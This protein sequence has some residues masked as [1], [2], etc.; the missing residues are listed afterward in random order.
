MPIDPRTFIAAVVSISSKPTPSDGPAPG[1]RGLW[2]GRALAAF[3]VLLWGGLVGLPAAAQM[4]VP[5][6]F[7][8]GPTGAAIYS[9]PIRVPPGTAG[10]APS[11]S[12]S[13][14]SQGGNGIVGMGW[15]LG[16]LPSIGRCPQTIAQDGVVG[17]VTFTTGDPLCVNGQRLVVVSGSYGADGAEYRAELDGFS[18]IISHGATGYGPAWFQVWTKAGQIMEF[19]HTADSLV[20]AQGI[21]APSS[22]ALDQISDTAGNYLTVTYAQNSATGETHPQQIN[23]TGNGRPNASLTPY[24]SVKFVYSTSRPDNL[25]YYVKGSA[26]SLSVLLTDIQTF[27]TTASGP[28]SLVADYHLTYGTGSGSGRS[29][30]SSIAQCT[31]AA[32]TNC[33]PSTT[34]GYQDGGN[35]ASVQAGPLSTQDSSVVGY[36][37]FPGNFTGSGRTD[38]LWDQEDIHGLSTGHRV[39]WIA[40]ANGTFKATPVVTG[41]GTLVGARPYLGSFTGNGRTDILWDLEQPSFLTLGTQQLWLSNGDGTFQIKNNIA[42]GSTGWFSDGK[43]DGTRP[44]VVDL[45]GDGRSDVLWLPIN[46]GGVPAYATVP[47]LVWMG[48]GDGT[49]VPKQLSYQSSSAVFNT[50]VGAATPYFADFDGDGKIDILWTN[51]PNSVIWFGNGDGTFREVAIV[52]PPGDSVGTGWQP[53]IGNFGDDGDAGILWDNVDSNGLST[54]TRK[55]WL[56]HGDGSFSL[57]SNFSNL[58]NN[59]SQSRIY[60]ADFQGTGR[61]DLFFDY[62]NAN[63]TSKGSGGQHIYRSSGNATFFYTEGADTLAGISNTNGYAPIIADFTGDGKADILWYASDVYGGA[64]GQFVGWTSDGLPSDVIQSITTGLGGVTQISHAAIDSYAGYVKGSSASYP[65]MDYTGALWV[66]SSWTQ[67]DGIGGA[68][69]TSIN[70]AGAQIDNS[71]RGFM[72]FGATVEVD[73]VTGVQSWKYYN[74]QFPLTGMLAESKQVASGVLLNDTIYSYNPPG[75]PVN[76]PPKKAAGRWLV[77]LSQLQTTTANDLETIGTSAKTWA[78]PTST[79]TFLRDF[80]NYNGSTGN[81]YGDLLQVKSVT[82]DGFTKEVDNTSLDIVD[83]NDWILGLTTQ[84]VTTSTAGPFGSTTTHHASFV[85]DTTAGAPTIGRLMQSFVEQGNTPYQ[86][87]SDYGYDVFGNRNL[88][89]VKGGDLASRTATTT[90]YD[91]KGQFPTTVSQPLSAAAT[92]VTQYQYDPRFGT[93]TSTM[94]NGVSTSADYDGFGRKS[95]AVAADG[96][97]VAYAYATVPYHAYGFSYTL[98]STPEA[99]TGT[100]IGPQTLAYYD[101]LGRNTVVDTQSFDGAT[102]SAASNNAALSRVQI[103]YDTNGNLVK[104]SR[105]FWATSPFSGQYAVTTYDV[106]NRPLSVTDADGTVTTHDYQGLASIDRNAN[107]QTLTTHRNSQGEVTTVTDALNNT[108]QYT[109]DGDGQPTTVMDPAGNAVMMKY[110]I[111]GRMV[112]KIDPDTGIWSYGYDTLSEPTSIVDAK[113]QTVTMGYDWAGRMVQRTERDLTSTWSYDAAQYGSSPYYGVGRLASVSTS[114]GFAENIAYDS[115][116]RPTVSTQTIGGA[117][118]SFTTGYDAYS[119]IVS[120]AYPSG[121]SLN[122]SFTALGYPLQESETGPAVATLS[123]INQVDVEFRVTQVAYGNGVQTTRGFN[124]QNGELQSIVAGANNAVQSLSYGYDRV[125]NIL[126]RTDGTQGLSET[127]GYDALNRLVSAQIGANAAVT[128]GY[129]QIGNLTSKSDIGTLTYGLFGGTGPHQLQSVTVS[130]SSPYAASYDAGTERSYTWTSFDMPATVSAGGQTI[131]F[132]YD[133]GHNRII[134]T[135]PQ[136]TTNYLNDPI[137]GASVERIASGGTAVWNN[138]FS[139]GEVV[140][141]QSSGTTTAKTLYFHRDGLGSV[142]AVSDGGGNVAQYRYDAWGARRYPTGAIDGSGQITSATDK[143]FTGQEELADVGLVHMNARLYDPLTARFV[144]ADP[145]GLQGGPNPY[146]YVYNNPLFYTDPTGLDGQQDPE[147]IT[148]YGNRPDPNQIGPA[149]FGGAAGASLS[150]YFS[151]AYRNPVAKGPGLSGTGI[152]TADQTNPTAGVDHGDTDDGCTYVPCTYFTDGKN[153]DGVIAGQRPDTIGTPNQFDGLLSSRT[154]NRG[155]R[156]ANSG[157]SQYWQ[158]WTQSTTTDANGNP[159]ETDVVTGYKTPSY[160]L[161]QEVLPFGDTMMFGRLPPVFSPLEQL[162]EG[163]AEG[164]GAGKAFPKSMNKQQPDGAPCTYCGTPTT[165]NPGPDQLNGDHIIPKSQGGNNSPENY[166][167]SCRTCNLQKG[168]RT[169]DDWLRAVQAGEAI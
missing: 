81:L 149:Q 168:A 130:S 101:I 124:T 111:R 160:Q 165:R 41:D 109:Y 24:A 133:A 84:S 71:G 169:P 145:I 106:L 137:S 83:T 4:Q 100:Q 7:A 93:V 27:T 67:S 70:Y 60:L 123:T 143:G 1:G 150:R 12:L 33:L 51:L 163:A 61:T 63:G 87:E 53:Y 126:S 125:G 161:A 48:N 139:A 56:G 118:Y 151:G 154:T 21:S 35:L 44:Y 121:F 55:L 104:A 164:P 42:Q 9:I 91:A 144:S 18:R 116:G 119:R 127:F 105:P 92:L 69:P 86:V 11:L 79:V 37:P 22:W 30:L 77:G 156:S 157:T 75:T 52:P 73:D 8:V 110:D 147:N 153:I 14:S 103:V 19:G 85:Y 49:F 132:S 167:P 29:L 38:I 40:N 96:T 78:M 138:Y 31:D 122:R 43:A 2:C 66:V 115:L 152:N 98:Q 28:N 32:A 10:M 113:G 23:Y 3:A 95:L 62:E 13:Y 47:Y 6:S 166:A 34:F 17:G 102:G 64:T 54:G 74:Q 58:T 25:K 120:I 65:S 155:A 16:G 114:Q 5:G 72:G 94:R 57:S 45:N 158:T 136:G 76:T 134:Q 108:T 46:R 141:T 80:D 89:L 162:P 107:S 148:V 128:Y 142:A 82:S 99:S 15:V 159:L 20:L 36:R 140:L 39:L 90:S 129:D 26:N 59:L 112:T 50:T 131:G 68:H 88:T 97:R 117:A 146:A 135:S